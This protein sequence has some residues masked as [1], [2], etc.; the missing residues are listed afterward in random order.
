MGVLLCERVTRIELALSAW[1]A[2]VLPL[3]YTRGGSLPCRQYASWDRSAMTSTGQTAAARTAPVVATVNEFARRDDEGRMAVVRIPPELSSDPRV[4]YDAAA[5]RLILP[6]SGLVGLLYLVLALLHPVMVG[7]NDGWILSAVAGISAVGLLGLAWSYRR[8]RVRNGSAVLSLAFLV[9][10][11][12]PGLHLWLTGQEWQTS[13][14]MLVVIGAGMAILA[15]RWNVGLTVLTWLAWTLGMLTIPG[16]N[17]SHWLIAMGMATLVGQLVRYGRRG[18]LA[19]A[20]DAV[21]L[22]IGLLTDAEELADGRQALLATI[23]HDVRTPRDRNRRHGRPVAPA[24][25]GRAH[26]RTGVG[27]AAL[28][29]RSD[30]DAQQSARPCAG[31]SR[32]SGGS[33]ER[34]GYLRDGQ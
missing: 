18:N 24:T 23:S 9:M 28:R 6:I 16:A 7:G 34:R 13:N 12:N 31:G 17:W 5:S 8:P 3:N 32:S 11:A 2:D 4:R 27:G 19:T 15:N 10:I 14:L 26:P 1:E 33:Q 30:D 21:N 20:A 25:T 22:Q 29:R